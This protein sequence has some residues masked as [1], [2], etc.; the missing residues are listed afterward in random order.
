MGGAVGEFGAAKKLGFPI[1]NYSRG[2][3]AENR[4]IRFYE[5]LERRF[6]KKVDGI[7]AVSAGQLKKLETFGIRNPNSWVVHNGVEIEKPDEQNIRESRKNIMAE[8]NLKE[9]SLLAVCVGRLSPEKGHRFL[10]EAVARL[11]KDFK[12][13]LFLSFI[14]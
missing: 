13:V 4:K 7:I 11:N 3:T 14:S 2:F 9:D 1:L 10:I 6:V 5:W 12:H 8:L